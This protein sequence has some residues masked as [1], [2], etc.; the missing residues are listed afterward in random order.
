VVAANI[1]SRNAKMDH[2]M[3]CAMKEPIVACCVYG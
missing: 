3:Q 1:I 2:V